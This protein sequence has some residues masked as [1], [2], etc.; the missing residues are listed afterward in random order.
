[1]PEKKLMLSLKKDG[2]GKDETSKTKKI[3]LKGDKE[4]TTQYGIYSGIRTEKGDNDKPKESE[5]ISNM[6]NYMKNNNPPESDT[7]SNVYRPKFSHITMAY[8]K[9]NQTNA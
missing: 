6:V 5:A 3:K 2:D 8:K 7:P 1:M 9:K 4:T